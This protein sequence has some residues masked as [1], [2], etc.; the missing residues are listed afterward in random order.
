MEDGEVYGGCVSYTDLLRPRTRPVRPLRAFK[1]ATPATPATPAAPA[2]PVA[3][4]AAP[5]PTLAE[6]RAR[7]DALVAVHVRTLELTARRLCRDP[8]AASDLVQDTLERAWRR[9]DI[10]DA[11]E[12]V[13]GWLLRVLRNTWIDGLRR[14]RAEVEFDDALAAPAAPPADDEPAWRADLTIDDVRRAI[15]QLAEPYRSVAALHHL[16]GQS[17]RDIAARLGIPRA[18]AA[19]R[20]HRAHCRL[21]KL[22]AGQ[23]APAGEAPAHIQ[24]GAPMPRK[25]RPVA[26]T[27]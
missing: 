23:L 13:R 5:A 26:R 10:L 27:A 6:Q 18:T 2:R 16:G 4:A 21:R 19:T 24:S 15:E 7:F 22:L 3:P 1:P 12:H 9:I 17:Y 25:P 11:D 8:A 20:L 14:Q